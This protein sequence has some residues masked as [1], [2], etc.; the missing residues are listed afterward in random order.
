MANTYTDTIT[1]VLYG[2]MEK[3]QQEP[4][5]L[6]QSVERNVSD[7]TMASF[8][9]NVE[10]LVTG[11]VTVT[12]STSYTPQ[13]DDVDGPADSDTKDTF[14]LSNHIYFDISILP[15][16]QRHAN[17]TIGW[18]KVLSQRLLKGFRAA[19]NQME[20]ELATAM[21]KGASKA[22]G[23]A[24]TT[25]FASNYD[26]IEDGMKILVDQGVNRYQG[27]ISLT[28]NTAASSNIRKLA[29]LQNV[30][31]SGNEALLRQGILLPLNGVNLR[32]SGQI[33]S[34]T[35]GTGSGYLVDLSAGYA[36]GSTTIHVDT[37]TG[38][39]LAGDVITFGS[40]TTEYVV[41]TGFD[42]DGDGDIVIA[43]PG[44]KTA[45][46][47]NDAVTI[48]DSYAANLLYTSSA[49]EFA[50]RAPDL[51]EDKAIFR[52]TISDEVANFNWAY[53]IYPGVGMQR[54]R[55]ETFTGYKVWNPY[56]LLLVKG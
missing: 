23:T 4:V 43:G 44:L 29:N 25:P 1:E 32:E 20:S 33:A 46:D 30:N 16:H 52:S 18:S 55:V 50:S 49:A 35:K 54:L 19:R 17:N 34:H 12:S 13:M 11:D 26:L 51:G 40:D 39:I 8:G 37:G 24:G 3:I 28:M 48:K 7:V 47:N 41:K 15:E 2:T 45:I 27:D 21:Y 31:T 56:Q 9:K 5:G 6:L 53:S 10:S 36:A 22:V 14:K 42:G 38:T